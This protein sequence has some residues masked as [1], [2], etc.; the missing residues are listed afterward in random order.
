MGFGLNAGIDDGLDYQVIA[1]AGWTDPI[2]PVI[3]G[4]RVTMYN[5][6]AGTHRLWSYSNG[7][8]HYVA[9]T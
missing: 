2:G 7:G 5:T 3:E 8:W 4:R 9:L 1:G 6:A